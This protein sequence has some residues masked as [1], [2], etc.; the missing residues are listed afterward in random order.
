MRKC[1][2]TLKIKE[3]E[4]KMVNKSIFKIKYNKK[5]FR[6]KAKARRETLRR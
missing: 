3:K 5:I 4:S 1:Q 2:N 6:S